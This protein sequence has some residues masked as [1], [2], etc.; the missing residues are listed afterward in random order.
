MSLHLVSEGL[1]SIRSL[2]GR[3][4]CTEKDSLFG[5]PTPPTIH[6]GCPDCPTNIT[7]GIA[8]AFRWVPV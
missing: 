3:S 4:W 2:T 1:F 5:M 8:V 6:I 7:I